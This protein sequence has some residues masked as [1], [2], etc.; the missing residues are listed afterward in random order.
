MRADESKIRLLK[1]VV[2]SAGEIAV[3]LAEQPALTL[4]Q[5][6]S[7]GPQP[8]SSAPLQ[9]CRLH[10]LAGQRQRDF[11]LPHKL[12]LPSF[13]A[14]HSPRIW[15]ERLC[16]RRSQLPQ[17]LHQELLRTSARSLSPQMEHPRQH[18]S[19]HRRRRTTMSRRQL[20]LVPS[21]SI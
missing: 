7:R 15:H 1:Q 6:H 14:H 17:Q 4:Q 20:C 13:A 12:S 8:R 2:A 16:R 10:P 18:Y 3:Q 5:R 19:R 11:T 21:P 9:S